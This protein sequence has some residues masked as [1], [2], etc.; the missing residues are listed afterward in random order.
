MLRIFSL[1]CRRGSLQSRGK[2][3]HGRSLLTQAPNPTA[4]ARDCPSVHHPDSPGVWGGDCFC[5]ITCTFI[6]FGASLVA[7]LVKNLPARRETWVRSLGRENPWRR[8]WQPTP[9]SLPG[10][11]H[12]Q[13][14]LRGYSPRGCRV[15][16]HSMMKPISSVQ[17]LS[18][19][20]LFVTPWTAA[21]QSMKP[22]VLS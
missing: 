20:Q 7:Q 3:Q 8:K 11:S 16:E 1:L 9:V 15:D 22:A 12:R 2:V 10:E 17:S 19:V 21:H 5:F 6:T 13:R 14:S 18:R 4:H